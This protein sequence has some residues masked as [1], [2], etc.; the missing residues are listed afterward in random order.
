MY[1][2]VVVTK[3]FPTIHFYDQDF[4]DIYE[5]T[6][7][8]IQDFWKKGTTKNGLR[9]RYFNYP[10]NVNIHQFETCLSTFFLVYSNK[11]YPVAP[12]LE[13]FYEKQEKNGAIRGEYSEA[14]GKPVLIDENP[15]GIHPPLFSWAEYNIYHKVGQKKRIK[16]IMPVLENYFAWIEKTFKAENG[17][18]S[19][20]LVACMLP[21]SPRKKSHYQIDFNCQQAL[22]A[23]YLSALGDILND[24]EISF[25]YKRAYFSIKTRINSLM[26]NEDDGFY[27]D[28][29]KKGVQ[30]SVK[31]IAAFWSLLAEIPNENKAN[32]LIEHLKDPN[33]FGLENPFP[34][35]AASEPMFDLQ[36][37]GG[38]GSVYPCFTFMVIKG[39]EK[40][41]RY[42]IAREYS[43]RH[44]YYML[45]TL[46]P[47][48]KK[49]GNLYEAYAPRNDGP[50]EWPGKE[51]FPRP[52][53]LPYAALASI[54]LMIENVIGL[55]ISLPR[56]TVD[57]IVPT[58][59]IMGIENLSLKRNMITIMSN[60]SGRG[61]EIRLE[62]E[63]LYYF[64]IN[65][66]GEK[67]KT[68]PIPSGKCSMLIDKL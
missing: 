61:W 66:L 56:K 28:L 11:N 39:L 14:A 25:K 42:D 13:N 59:E 23:L 24:K 32:R 12:M 48:G 16:E 7:A 55:Y 52:L 36:G 29:D 47:E 57:W 37:K 4:V 40:Y 54:T 15:E 49:K 35:L 43:I 67:K 33:S 9:N 20:P 45:D 41:G 18:Y 2:G 26:W 10:E 3:D 53:F 64:T 44:L 8:W 50:A 21:N 30:I 6:W 27:Y 5:R 68:L 60:K 34:T 38:R 1:K 31:T 62:S 22:N 65:L 17:L 63:K 19:V 51:N 46:H 58:L